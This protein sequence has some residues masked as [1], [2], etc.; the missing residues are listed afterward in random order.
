MFLIFLIP[1]F[2]DFNTR[3]ESETEALT[4]LTSANLYYNAW[5]TCKYGI[6]FLTNG[7]EF[8]F[9]LMHN[10]WQHLKKV[11]KLPMTSVFFYWNEIR[12]TCLYSVKIYSC[13]QQALQF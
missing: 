6:I 8:N 1:E 13:K 10:K 12:E 7:F 9:L 4:N 11:K 3:T 2:G 5:T